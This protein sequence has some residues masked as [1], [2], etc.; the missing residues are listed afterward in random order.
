MNRIGDPYTP[1]DGLYECLDCGGRTESESH[2]GDCPSCGG[3]VHNIAIP[4]E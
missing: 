3:T 1:N 2:I 4:R